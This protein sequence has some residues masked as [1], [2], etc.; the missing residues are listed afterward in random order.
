MAVLVMSLIDYVTHQFTNSA[1]NTP[2]KTIRGEG[3]QSLIALFLD[4]HAIPWGSLC[5]HAKFWPA[6]FHGFGVTE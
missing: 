2:H 5:S 1:Q 6:R 3:L 4:I